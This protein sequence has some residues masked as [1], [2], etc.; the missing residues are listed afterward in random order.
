MKKGNTIQET[1][2]LNID[3]VQEINQ[4]SPLRSYIFSDDEIKCFSHLIKYNEDFSN[5]NMLDVYDP[6]T[7]YSVMR[8]T[9]KY[10]AYV[11][12]QMIVLA[13]KKLKQYSDI[14]DNI[15]KYIEDNNMKQNNNNSDD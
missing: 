12:H 9:N 3:Y 8:G 11:K 15:E 13:K 5:E 7:K 2:R 4:N 14:I 6:R 10:N 1:K